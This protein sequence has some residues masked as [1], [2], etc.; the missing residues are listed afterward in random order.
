MSGTAA[1]RIAALAVFVGLRS[2]IE[3]EEA[4]DQEPPT[5]RSRAWRRWRSRDRRRERQ[6]AQ[7][8]ARMRSYFAAQQVG[9]P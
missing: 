4:H 2:A 3:Q 5:K 6:R 7:L 8:A 9:E 1:Q